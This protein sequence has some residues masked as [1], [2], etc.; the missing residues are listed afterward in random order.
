M[1]AMREGCNFVNE[2]NL[3]ILG[4]GESEIDVPADAT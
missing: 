1:N 4:M 2:L 3:Q